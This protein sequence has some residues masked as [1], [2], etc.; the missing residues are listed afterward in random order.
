MNYIKI[1]LQRRPLRYTMSFNES[2]VKCLS[3][4]FYQLQQHYLALSHDFHSQDKQ[5]PQKFIKFTLGKI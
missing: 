4:L 2:L 5:E 3:T 1:K